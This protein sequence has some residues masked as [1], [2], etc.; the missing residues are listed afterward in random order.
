[1]CVRGVRMCVLCVCQC[2]FQ[3]GVC[4]PVCAR[5]CV[6]VGVCVPARAVCVCGLGVYVGRHLPSD[7]LIYLVLSVPYVNAVLKAKFA[8]NLHLNCFV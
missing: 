5:A 1:M 3:F 7:F 6:S 4:V 2:L 8:E